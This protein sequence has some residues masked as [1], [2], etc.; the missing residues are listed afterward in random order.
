MIVRLKKGRTNPTPIIK[1]LDA[2]A[3]TESLAAYFQ[4][5]GAHSIENFRSPD[6]YV[7][8]LFE[9][10][11]GNHVIDFRKYQQRDLQVHISYPG[12]IHS[13]ETGADAL[14]HKLIMDRRIIER[15]LSAKQLSCL[16]SNRYPVIDISRTVFDDLEYEFT[17][18][19]KALKEP[20][21]KWDI[22]R[23]RLQL[24]LTVIS[25]LIEESNHTFLLQT[26][27]HPVLNNFHFLV[28]EHFRTTRSVSAYADK[29]FITPNYLTILCK[30]HLGIPA[31]KIIDQRIILE[32]KRLLLGT[33]A[34]VK[35][36]THFLGFS[37]VPNFSNFIKS[38]TGLTPREYKQEKTLIE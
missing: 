32:A 31:G 6:R 15:T 26:D 8:L 36:I 35:E 22:V 28:E 16:T 21:P 38:N 30:K 27:S 1:D 9:K 29:L 25:H 34:S 2:E 14:G 23:S 10:C 17:T 33:D 3:A 13:W 4:M 12:Q 19:G 5:A 24:V 11:S 20:L 7:F 18:I 37:N